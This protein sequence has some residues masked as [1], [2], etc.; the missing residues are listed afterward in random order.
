LDFKGVNVVVLGLAQSGLAAVELLVEKG[1]EVSACDAQPLDRLP[2]AAAALARLQAPFRLQSREALADA[3]WIVISPGVPADL[4]LLVEA[5]RRG[6]RVI[7]EVELAGYY[8]QGD[9]IGITGSNGKTT[10]TALVGHMLAECGIPVQVGG[11]IGTV[12]A[13]A[14]VATSRP[15]QWNVLELSSFQLETIEWF[16]AHI[17]VELNVTQDH[18]DRHHS[19]ERYA[20]AKARLVETLGPLDW[21]VL[22]ADDPILSE[23]T[24]QTPSRLAW[25]SLTRKVTPGVWLDG[26]LL[27]LDGKPLIE[28]KDIPLRGRHNIENVMAASV[29]AS[30]AGAPL[31]GIAAAIRSF[32]AVEH[33][34]E[35]VATVQGVE[36]YNDSK[37]TNVDS[38]LKAIDAFDGGLWIILGGKDKGSDYSPLAAPLKA[39]ARA[40]LLIGAATPLI[41]AGL[42]G[43]VPVVECGTLERAVATAFRD[44]APGDTILLAPACASFDQFNNYEHRGRVFKELV[45]RLAAGR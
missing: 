34:L 10:T 20:A 39:K 43:A 5:R 45:A 6:A 37:A 4:D 28:A 27:V 19:F 41:A 3:A 44:A 7:G 15:G 12:P 9:T 33:R 8:L 26:G 21:A 18:L 36:F 14:L 30:L 23:F 38:T 16:Q 2:E 22:N 31:E 11:N 13:T 42:A 17:G 1:A 40:A 25:F 24:M 32:R 35:Y 29:A